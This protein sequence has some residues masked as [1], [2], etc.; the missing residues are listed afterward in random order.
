MSAPHPQTFISR[1][2]RQAGLQEVAPWLQGLLHACPM[3]AYL[4][5]S[6]GEVAIHH[7]GADQPAPEESP[8][9]RALWELLAAPADAVCR[10]MISL[11]LQS[12]KPVNFLAA[13]AGRLKSWQVR[14]VPDRQGGLPWL[15]VYCGQ[16]KSPGWYERAL[17]VSE[18]NLQALMEVLPEMAAL[19]DTAGR[20]LAV[21]RPAAAFLGR[22]PGDILGKSL[23]AL[24]EPELVSAWS[25]A[26]LRAVLSGRPVRRQGEHRGR[27]LEL[28]WQ[29]VG[30]PNSGVQRLVVLARDLTE[31]RRAE[32]A[33]R[34]SELRYRTL[35]EN[36]TDGVSVYERYPGK[37][38]RRLL[39]CNTSY[40]A[41]A[42]RSKEELLAAPDI[43][44]LQIRYHDEEG[45]AQIQ[46]H[47]EQ[48]RPYGGT[49]SWRR[50]D[51]RENFHE[52][53]A[54][55]VRMEERILVLGIDRD[56][57][58]RVRAEVALKES[59]ERLR[60]LFESSPE[61]VVVCTA[62]RGVISHL[63]PAASLIFGYAPEELVGRRLENLCLGPAREE[64]HEG[65]ARLEAHGELRLDRL[66]F[67]RADG[68][69]VYADLIAGRASFGGEHH[70]LIYL[71]DVSESMITE[72]ALRQSEKKFSQ[73]FKISPVSLGILTLDQGRVLEVNEALLRLTGLEREELV[74][75]TSD[76]LD[77]WVDGEVVQRLAER[78]RRKGWV[79]G[80]ELQLQDSRG[81]VKT[82]LAS[83]EISELG[84]ELCVI[85][86][87]VDITDRKQAE[88]QLVESQLRLRE[89]NAELALTEARERRELA[90]ALH[91]RVSQ[92]LFMSKFKLSELRASLA[93]SELEESLD[94]IVSIMDQSLKEARALTYDL[95][96]P[97]LYEHG[98]AAALEW[99]AEDYTKR[100]GLPVEFQNAD[101][102]E[103]TTG[104]LK[105][106]LFRAARELLMNVIKHAG[107][108]RAWLQLESGEGELVITV[109]DDGRGFDPEE[110]EREHTFSFG[111]YSIKERLLGMGGRMQISSEPGQGSRVRL[112]APSAG[113]AGS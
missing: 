13:H 85:A 52:F 42:G 26:F 81:Q 109:A 32:Q 104:D 53:R 84:D 50:P 60:V 69:L 108:N 33:W 111:L 64:L 37:R 25:P 113:G 3:E 82:L 9:G 79:R 66:P 112:V 78:L 39:D 72:E 98:L 24:L 61:G 71:R 44:E 62:G 20:V 67:L 5:D 87:M 51:G 41:M 19:V 38:E 49:A 68:E 63:N 83:A 23:Q 40:A 43:R 36:V 45:S 18:E 34:E 54:V 46:A 91:D 27:V 88:S 75:R 93:G 6:E 29:P 31:Q 8:V 70:L 48:G 57:T 77:L 21:N 14:P 96:L 56:I 76:E 17:K 7:P 11:C 65:I 73:L 4:L 101:G 12:R 107:A 74:G 90:V 105:V 94:E 100:H 1:S 47:V 103:S 110:V 80:W 106:L 58:E 15:A 55:P 86:A 89:L 28:I 59:E 92:N 16:A 30:S 10:R 22:Q 35:F 99:L 2:G 95:S 102:Q 97:I